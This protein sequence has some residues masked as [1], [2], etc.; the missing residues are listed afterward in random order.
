MTASRARTNVSRESLADPALCSP[1]TVD[2]IDGY[3][4][5]TRDAPDEVDP[6]RGQSR[7]AFA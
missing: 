3:E 5:Y 6:T 4:M 1:P 2:G 7:G